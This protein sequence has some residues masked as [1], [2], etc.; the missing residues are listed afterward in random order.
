MAKVPAI[1]MSMLES[2]EMVSR[3]Y[4]IDRAQQDAFGLRSQQ[5]TAHAQQAGL[6]ADEIVPVSTTMLVVNKETGQTS[7]QPVTLTRDEGS[8]PQ[9]KLEDLQTSSRHSKA[10]CSLV[11]VNTSQAATPASFP[12]GRQP[13]C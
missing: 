13:W 5:R 1:Y 12:M 8:R 7:E 11:K 6:F 10:G 4:K 9:T 2:A 3:R